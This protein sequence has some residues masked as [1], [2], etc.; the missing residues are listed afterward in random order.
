MITIIHCI[1]VGNIRDKTRV[2]KSMFNYP[3]VPI[4][5]L[6]D[7]VVSSARAKLASE[8]VFR[9]I[10]E[11]FVITIH[12]AVPVCH[13]PTL[14]KTYSDFWDDFSPGTP[15]EL[16]LLV[17]AILYTSMANSSDLGTYAQ[18]SALYELYEQLERGLDLTSYYVTP[19][20]IAIM[21]LQGLLI[22]NTFRASHLAPFTAFGFLPLAIRFAQ[23]LRLHIDRNTGNDLDRN[24]Q[25]RLWWHLLFLDVE[26]TIASGLPAIIS[27]VSYTTNMPS[28]TGSDTIVE[29][30]EKTLSPI[31]IAMQGHREWAY[32]MQ[33]W[34]ERKPEQH[35]IMRFGRV[36]E[37]LLKMVGEDSE[38]EWAH[39]YLQILIDRAYCML[40][41]RF[42]QLDLFMGMDCHSE[43]VKYVGFSVALL[44]FIEDYCRTARSFLAKFLKLATLSQPLG[45]NWF[46]P[47]LIQPIHALMIL[48]VHLEGCI[49]PDEE[50]ALSRDLI[51]KVFS[52]RVDR[53]LNGDD[54]INF[55]T[56]RFSNLRHHNSR[57][58]ALITLKT[59]VWQKLGW[60]TPYPP[61]THHSPDGAPEIAN[62][63]DGAPTQ[64]NLDVDLGIEDIMEEN[65]ILVSWDEFTAGSSLDTGISNW[66]E[67]NSLSA[68]FFME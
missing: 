15:A 52:L 31:M 6:G 13:V 67:W 20:P 16:L 4:S 53:I 38:S 41:L 30:G 44:V 3:F 34:Y 5:S 47:G 39:V 1:K 54:A 48:L 19:S 2:S 29:N 66:D 43:V 26:S 9:P 32:R 64:T 55:M 36:I 28:I 59:R 17:S 33:I 24:I 27:S 51:D 12:P 50:A 65:S 61:T 49:C 14:R 11:S 22:M 46:V 23:S 58:L 35:E 63:P 10:F 21:L 57:Y 40:G 8:N 60:S 45:Y 18:A 37:G 25:R 68:G 56:T 42:W 7:N 62:P